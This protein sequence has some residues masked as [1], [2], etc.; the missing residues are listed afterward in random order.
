MNTISPL[1]SI[2]GLRRTLAAAQRSVSSVRSFAF[3]AGERP[4][5][6]SPF[7]SH[8]PQIIGAQRFNV[9][10]RGSRRF[11]LF[12]TRLKSE[13]IHFKRGVRSA[14]RRN[15]RPFGSKA[16]ENATPLPLSF[17]HRA[18]ALGAQKIAMRIGASHA[19]SLFLTGLKRKA[20]WIGDRFSPVRL[21]SAFRLPPSAFCLLLS[22]R[23]AQNACA[24]VA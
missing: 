10:N 12:L 8:L 17:S 2:V 23:A 15:T 7:F 5:P 13:G 4:T 3:K 19:F 11:S 20:G 18:Q 1:L 24:T 14:Y 9:R 21:L 16:G 22:S 6:S